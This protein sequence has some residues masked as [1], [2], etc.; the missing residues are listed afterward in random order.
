MLGAEIERA[1][2]CGREIS[3]YLGSE[4]YTGIPIDRD[5]HFLRIVCCREF[6]DPPISATWILRLDRIDSICVAG[7]SWDPDRLDRV[8]GDSNRS[9]T[10]SIDPLDEEPPAAPVAR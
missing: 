7:D 10:E 9:N 4:C 6:S 1:I 5:I 2:E 8:M 3:L